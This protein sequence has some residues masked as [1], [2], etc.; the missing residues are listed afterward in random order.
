MLNAQLNIFDVSVIAIVGLSTLIAFFRG[1]VKEVL[2]LGAWIGAAFITIYTFPH[3]AVLLKPYMQ[4][5]GIA[6]GAAALGTYITAIII[7]SIINSIIF[8]FI[9]EG[10]E[11]GMLDNMLGLAFGMLRG[12]FIVS[13]GFLLISLIFDKKHYP[14]W[15]KSA[16]TKEYVE[17][18]A[19]MLS[20]IAPDYLNRIPIGRNREET[21]E[22]K[23]D[24][25]LREE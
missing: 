5:E 1:F 11:V 22:E 2:S 21:D 20:S 24:S 12:A 9:K 13:L 16:Q 19:E 14:E 10:S 15:I 7:L 23:V 8:K 4:N 6:S 18:G 25:L 17:K 3:V